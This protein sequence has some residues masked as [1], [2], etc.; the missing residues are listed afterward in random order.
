MSKRTQQEEVSVD[1]KRSRAQKEGHAA[2]C[3][4]KNCSGCDVGDVEI[5]FV[6]KGVDGQ[7]IDTEPT[8]QELLA[9]AI[10]ES[11]ND[12]NEEESNGMARRLF[13]IALDKFQ[14][15]EPENRIGYATCLIELGKC[16]HV[17]ESI[18]EGLDILRGELKKDSEDKTILIRLASAAISLVAFLRKRQNDYF[19]KQC[20]LL[21]ADESGVDEVAH[22]ELLRK[23]RTTP[24]EEDLANEAIGYLKSYFSSIAK[25]GE[26]EI[27]LI[28]PV[29][30]EFRGYGQLLVEPSHKDLCTSVF[31]AATDIVKELPDYEKDDDLLILWAACLIHTEHF[32]DNKQE[33]ISVM[34]QA[35]SLLMKANDV[36][37][38]KYKK[39]NP[40]VWEMYAMLRIN[41]SNMAEGEDEALDLYDEAISSFKRA[42]ELDPGIYI[43]T[44]EVISL[45]IHVI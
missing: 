35:D 30:H 4:D 41:Q 9:M 13:D 1:N 18:R 17:E 42:H 22:R 36:Y 21:D 43:Y 44:T 27:K 31:N 45:T 33:R 25:L 2:E 3:T 23:Q 24:E 39:G 29:L 14:K 32:L 38:A 40:W 20:D 37:M 10:E 11:S 28:K 6:R 7:T 19:D 8:A 5:S 26:E 12:N 34:K 15:E 16:I